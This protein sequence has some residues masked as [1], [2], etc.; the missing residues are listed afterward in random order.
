M[1]RETTVAGKLGK[2]GGLQQ[3]RDALNANSG[4]LKHLE[5]SLMQFDGMVGK[6]QE[7]TSRQGA[8][9]AEK[10]ETTKQLRETLSEAQRLGTVLRLAVKQH[11][12][13]RAEKLAEFN[14][15]PFR[16]RKASAPLPSPRVDPKQ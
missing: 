11:F 15:Q 16:G 2:L 9:T 1:A 4:N 12:G 3:L 7:L 5:V 14:L 13:I 10:Q 6:A 8:L